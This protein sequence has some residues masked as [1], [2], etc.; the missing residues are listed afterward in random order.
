[1]L[2]TKGYN[3]TTL[4]FFTVKTLS[5]I[6]LVTVPLLFT[7]LI[8]TG[9]S[10]M[11]NTG[12]DP[13]PGDT[14]CDAP[15]CHSSALMSRDIPASGMHTSHLTSAK[16]ILC[17]D[18]HF[19]YLNN[20]LHKNGMINGYNSR[21][22]QDAEGVIISFN[23]SKNATGVFDASTHNCSSMDCHLALNWYSATQISCGICHSEGSS[24][25]PSSGSHSAHLSAGL[26]C[27]NCHSG[28][29]ESSAHNDGIS[30]TGIPV[31]FDS[32]NPGGTYSAGECS[33]LTCHGSSLDPLSRGTDTT[34]VWGNASTGACGTCHMITTISQ[35]SHGPHM[36]YNS[37]DKC[38]ND[39]AADPDHHLPANMPVDGTV[40]YSF[41]GDADAVYSAPVCSNV[42]CHSTSTP[43]WGGTV[44]C[45]DCHQPGNI[46]PSPP[47]PGTN[48]AHTAHLTTNH[49]IINDIECETCHYN[50]ISDP[51]HGNEVL[52][53]NS[54]GS[55]IIAF[56]TSGYNG[57]W[58]TGT[59]SC[60]LLACHGDSSTWYTT[61][62]LNSC[63]DCHSAAYGSY[64]PDPMT[65]SNNSLD[66]A[67]EGQHDLTSHSGKACTECHYDY[68]TSGTH[69]DGSLDADSDSVTLFTISP[70]VDANYDF[71]WEDYGN[72]NGQ[73][74]STR[75]GSGGCHGNGTEVDVWQK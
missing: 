29:K 53:N 11:K 39:G 8:F 58:D 66:P 54:D 4:T 40:E 30:D 25:N 46:F 57:S 38:H 9:C 14:G 71:S 2:F 10:D 13:G 64:H 56:D 63:S 35:G 5:G 70:S 48:G 12:E 33:D 26:T 74:T 15:A 67:N 37:C 18:C 68:I 73:C 20:P 75:T 21:T 16:I 55:S 42:D 41:E 45:T 47:D 31:S 34:P 7:V 51:L 24:N 6:F 32:V 69:L 36:S 52:N 28:Y 23:P 43:V 49:G 72:G 19:N 61:G 60:T 62:V 65:F 17:T 44:L 50:Y 1:M 27:G 59:T 3:I 22:D